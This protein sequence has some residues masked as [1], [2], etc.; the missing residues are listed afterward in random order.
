MK[1]DD[2]YIGYLP[3]A[4]QSLKARLRI[5]VTILFVGLIVLSFFT[6]TNQ[7]AFDKTSFDY[8]QFTTLKGSVTLDPVPRLILNKG[9][10][11]KNRQVLQS[12]LLVNFGKSGVHVMFESLQHKLEKPLESYEFELQGTL[13]YGEGKTVFELT[14]E[15]ESIISY[16]LRSDEIPTETKISFGEVELRGEI[17]D[18]KCYFGVMKPGYGKVHR[19]CAIRC[20]SGGIAPVLM[21][22]DKDGNKQYILVTD[23]NGSFT[24]N[25]SNL[26]GKNVVLVGKLSQLGDWLLLD[27]AASATMGKSNGLQAFSNPEL[28]TANH[29]RLLQEVTICH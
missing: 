18:A 12:I 11:T 22:R 28:L 27:V 23:N 9:D 4:P 10:D 17:L 29:I 20:I 3:K 26:I 25:R 1:K 24:S 2:F 7:F 15:S 13:I 16:Q 5:V 6:G 21:A 14:E 8:G 19:S